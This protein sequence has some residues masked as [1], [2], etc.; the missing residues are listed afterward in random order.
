M[1]ATSHLLTT[2]HYYHIFNRG[3]AKQLIYTDHKHYRR[4]LQTANFYTTQGHV[5]RLSRFLDLKPER[6]LLYIHSMDNKPKLVT[7]VSF[8]LMPNH[9]HLLLKQTTDDG[10]SEFMR[11]LSN[12][13]TRYFNTI[14]NRVGPVFKGKYKFVRVKTDEQLIHLSRYIHLNPLVSGIITKK[15]FANYPY[16]SHNQFSNPNTNS[17]LRINPQ[18]ILSHFKTRR[19]YTN[20][21][22][23]H[24]DYATTIE[25]FKHLTHDHED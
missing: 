7:V 6:Q 23:D 3:V 19:N 13:Y 16:S 15:E 12:S 18:N 4:F 21:C 24:A 17:I 9:F 1:P 10:I 2:N 25:K 8:C 20:F 5:Y 22:L 14:N 11:L